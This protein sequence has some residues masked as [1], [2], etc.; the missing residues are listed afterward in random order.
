[1]LL[2]CTGLSFIVSTSELL[3]DS[4]PAP[5]TTLPNYLFPVSEPNA[6]NSAGDT[7][8]QEGHSLEE[9]VS[10]EEST[11]KTGKPKKRSKRE[12]KKCVCVC[13]QGAGGRRGAVRENIG[14]NGW[15]PADT[16]RRQLS[17]MAVVDEKASL[18][19]KTWPYCLV[20]P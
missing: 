19:I 17:G 7:G 11:K 10:K 5:A 15:R 2:P 9:Q 12:R 3:P 16:F 1:M 18:Y 8:D 13:L 20:H 4:D 6:M 14:L